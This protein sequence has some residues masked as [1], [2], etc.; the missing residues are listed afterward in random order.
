MKLTKETH[1]NMSQTFEYP[2][3][4]SDCLYLKKRTAKPTIGSIKACIEPEI[5]IKKTGLG[6]KA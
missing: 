4:E 5:K 1:K 6:K 2:N 3:L